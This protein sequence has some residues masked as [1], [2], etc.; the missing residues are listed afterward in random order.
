MHR[1][2]RKHLSSEL[3]VKSSNQSLLQL[4]TYECP[5]QTKSGEFYGSREQKEQNIAVRE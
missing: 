3:S 4:E 5:T 2:K 1:K